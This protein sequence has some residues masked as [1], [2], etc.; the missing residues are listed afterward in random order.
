MDTLIS[1]SPAGIALQVAV[2][3]IVYGV[4]L[5][6]HAGGPLLLQA[7]QRWVKTELHAAIFAAG[8]RQAKART[9]V[10]SPS[11]SRLRLIG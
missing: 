8:D 5:L 6:Y 2:A 3:L 4:L 9:A 7:L 10:P 11:P 1:V